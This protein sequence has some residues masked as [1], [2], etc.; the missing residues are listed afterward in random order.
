MGRGP[1]HIGVQTESLFQCP[2]LWFWVFWASPE[3]ILI[4]PNYLS[5]GTELDITVMADSDSILDCQS[6]QKVLSALA[7]YSH[8][9]STVC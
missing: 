1:T 8:H 5:L 3:D 6:V 2:E 9:C 7:I 4:I